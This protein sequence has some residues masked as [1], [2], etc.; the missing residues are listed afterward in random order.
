MPKLFHELR[1]RLLR[2]GVAPRHVRRY[3]GELGDHFADIVAEEMRAG[4]S[5]M[6]AESAALVRL[7]SMDDLARA[8]TEKRQFR[9][10]CGRAPWA[11]FGLAPLFL[12]GGAWLIAL[13]ILWSGWK[14]FLPEA[15]TPFIPIVHGVAIFYF[16][17]GRM[18]YFTAPVLIGW[19]IGIIAAHQRLKLIWPAVGLILMSLLGSMAQVHVSRSAESGS[20]GQV[21]L[22]FGTGPSLQDSLVNSLVILLLSALP[23][24]IW[25]LQ[26]VRSVRG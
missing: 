12:L 14:M 17:V 4:R 5:Q 15:A 20:G 16:G 19:G 9:S 11:A 21:S 18:L 23:Y 1:E 25:R 6:E 7:G 22:D 26:R 2:A 8:L 10:W 24:V 3:L 13:F